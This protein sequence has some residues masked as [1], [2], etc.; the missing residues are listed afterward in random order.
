M[1]QLSYWR[2]SEALFSHALTAVPNNFVA[3]H[4]LALARLKQGRAEEAVTF[5][6]EALRIE[7]NLAEAENEL[8]H[9]L[10]DTG[11]VEE[12]LVHLGKALDLMEAAQVHLGKTSALKTGFAQA[13][14]DL[15]RAL[16]KKGRTIEAIAQFQKALALSPDF[17]EA[18]NNLA[19]ALGTHGQVESGTK[20]RK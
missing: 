2:N 15:G 6:R 8:S 19:D 4:N 12:A 20:E 16:F 9:A 1:Q 14:C 13:H 3:Y 17:A 18:R 10:A 7:P 11:Q 5:L